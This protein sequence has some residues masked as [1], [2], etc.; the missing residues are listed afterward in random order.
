MDNFVGVIRVLTTDDPELL[1]A[2]GRLIERRFGLTTRTMCIPDQPTGIYD[3]ESERRA[4]PKII[5]VAR[6]LVAEGASAILVSCAAD[7]AV[8]ELRGELKVPV[9]GAGSSVAAVAV[10][11]ADRIGVLNLNETAPGP[12]RRILGDRFVGED[13]PEGVRN[14]PDLLTDWGREAALRAAERLVAAGAGVLVLACTG[15]AT[16]GMADEL[17]RRMGVLAVDPVVAAG[18]MASY[19]LSRGNNI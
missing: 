4:I 14:S 3:D 10:G 2:H 16:I 1:A 17:S 6:K 8:S 9:I 7:P 19:T 11:L 5:H 13:S 12:V 18:L 15:Y